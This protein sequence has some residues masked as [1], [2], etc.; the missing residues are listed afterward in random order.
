MLIFIK[1]NAFFCSLLNFSEI[2]LKLLSPGT[3]S[4]KF[5]LA[6]SLKASS[7][8]AE[9]GNILYSGKCSYNLSRLY[10][11]PSTSIL[12]AAIIIGLVNFLNSEAK[13]FKSVSLHSIG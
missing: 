13:F 11:D 10:F 9:H 2:I 12:F 7:E 6:A 4:I 1:S 3:Y 8:S 5:R